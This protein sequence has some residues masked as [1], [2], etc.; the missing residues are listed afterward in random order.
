MRGGF[1]VL[2]ICKLSTREKDYPV[3]D[4]HSC[5]ES[6][7]PKEQIRSLIFAVTGNISVKKGIVMC[8]IAPCNF[9]S[10]F[11]SRRNQ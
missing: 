11:Q 6:F 1:Y 4:G 5:F 8:N 2:L 7:T 3:H 10:T 9:N